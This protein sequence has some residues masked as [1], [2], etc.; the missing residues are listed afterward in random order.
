MPHYRRKQ[1][2]YFPKGIAYILE[3][4]VITGKYVQFLCEE[5]SQILCRLK[6]TD[7]ISSKSS[8]QSCT[9]L[10]FIPMSI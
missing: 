3:M 1:D 9:L 4:N 5:D 10:S 6:Q 8:F 7:V 2:H